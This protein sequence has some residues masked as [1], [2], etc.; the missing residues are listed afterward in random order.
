M[1]IP[2]HLRHPGVAWARQIR[3]GTQ[4]VAD[5]LR[6]AGAW[7]G[8]RYAPLFWP[9][10]FVLAA[11]SV[12]MNTRI[13]AALGTWGFDAFAYWRPPHYAGGLYGPPGVLEGFGVYKYSP[14]F[15][16]LLTPLE[17]LPWL[18]F[19][20][21]WDVLLLATVIWLCGRW[22]LLAIAM[23]FV[24]VDLGQGNISVL[25][26]AAM[27]VGF[28]RPAAW[29]FVLLTKVTPG[30]GLLWFAVRRE[31][32]SLLI[33]LVATAVVVVASIVIH[34]PGLWWDWL[35]SL[36]DHASSVDQVGHQLVPLGLAPRLAIA[37]LFVVWGA[38]T[39]RR[40]TVIVAATIA[41]P[42]L[43]PAALS[44]LLGV[45]GLRHL[46][47]TATTAGETGLSRGGSAVPTAAS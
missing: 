14:A 13:F 21:A 47:Q 16:D 30:V 5:S 20:I 43:W 19:L 32:R 26:A 3:T 22:T 46:G 23:P 7:L 28:R 12:V 33:A 35:A 41:T 17:T 11:V 31:W 42:A 9:I 37:A 25:L 34:G 1:S 2:M 27:V 8:R 4:G 29:A 24:F 6:G 36:D 38:R 45:I 10:S 44:A 18:Q 15:L 40:W 39:G